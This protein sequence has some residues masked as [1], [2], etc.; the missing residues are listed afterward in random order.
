[1]GGHKEILS[2]DRPIGSIDEDL[3]NRS[4]FST[5]IANAIKGWQGNDSLVIG[6][7]GDWGSGKSSVKNM[8]LEALEKDNSTETIEFNPWM[9]SGYDRLLM[10]F[11]DEV[12][13]I[14]GGEAGEEVNRK[15]E[16]YSKY[17][18]VGG[19]ALANLGKLSE[20]IGISPLSQALQVTSNIVAVSAEGINSED[21]GS[22]DNI[23]QVS[24]LKQD[25]SSSLKEMKKTIVVVLDDIDRLQKSEIPLLFQIIK[26]NVDFPNLVFLLLCDRKYVENALEEVSPERG[27]QYLEKIVQVGFNL[28]Q[29]NREQ[30]GVILN[31][32]L[33]EVF[34]TEETRMRFEDEKERWERIYPD[35]ILP[36]L[37]NIRDVNRLISSFSFTLGLFIKD[38]RLEVNIVDL[39]GM[40]VI[41]IFEPDLYNKIPSYKY[42][43]APDFYVMLNNIIEQRRNELEVLFEGYEED[44]KAKVTQL[45]VEL[46]PLINR[47]VNKNPSLTRG[48]DELFR[49]L[50]ISQSCYFDRYFQFVIT[51]EEL[52]RY[53]YEEFIEKATD[54]EFVKNFL[55]EH[56]QKKNLTVLLNDLSSYIVNID[57]SKAKSL[58]KAFL[59]EFEN[60]ETV[61]SLGGP[62]SFTGLIYKILSEFDT[63]KRGEVLL[64][65][66]RI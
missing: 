10:A 31:D 13:A 32:K 61:I 33:K 54:E 9:F 22:G 15:W 66:I 62:D 43:L 21:K 1:M 49:N 27:S 50:S 65:A 36:F 59:D 14:L 46:F 44:R 52:P 16:A 45:L 38:A 34:K 48:E 8:I 29:L 47:L 41:R 12:G 30:L 57:E 35:A 2:S 25:L 18:K 53:I 60:F 51:E 63:D 42:I 3:L 17:L 23:E 4:N 19:V 64:S 11:F 26:I 37:K 40:E 7:F 24:K 28:P 5:S 20:V 39:I 58:V 6:L 55:R 56:S